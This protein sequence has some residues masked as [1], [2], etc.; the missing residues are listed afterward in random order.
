V[1]TTLDWA[2][3]YAGM[4]W[5]IIPIPPGEKYPKGFDRWH[6]LAVTSQRTIHDWWGNLFPDHGI[7]IATGQASGLWVLDVDD[8]TGGADTLADLE[9]TYGA[10]PD[11]WEVLTPGG[12][13]H[14]YFAWP[15]GATIRNDQAGRIGP[16]LDVRV[17]GGQVLAPPSIHPNGGRYEREASSPNHLAPAPDWLVDLLTAPERGAAGS[18][19]ASGGLLLSSSGDRPGDR[20]GLSWADL[21]RADGAT[22]IDCR[23]DRETNEWYELWSRPPMPGEEGFV[24]HTSASLN[25]KGSGVLK[26]FTPNWQGVTLDGERWS[27][28]QDKTYTRFGYW[29]VTRWGGDFKRAAKEADRLWPKEDGGC[30]PMAMV[31]SDDSSVATGPAADGRTTVADPAGAGPEPRLKPDLL[32]WA[33]DWSTFFQRDRTASDWLIEPLFARGRAHALYAAA[34]QGKSYVVLAVCAAAALGRPVL[35]R[36]AGDPLRILYVDYEMT[37][38]DLFDRLE[39]FGYDEE[40]APQ[41]AETL[42]YVQLPAIDPLDTAAGARTVVEAARYLAV[43]LVVIDTTARAISGEENDA[44]TYRDLARL[45]GVP[46]KAEGIAWVRI[47]HAG[48]EAEKGQRGSS[49]KNDDVDVVW[50]LKRGDEG[51]VLTAT[52]RRMSWVPERVEL[53]AHEGE[54]GVEFRLPGGG[55]VVHPDGTWHAVKA[56]DDLGLPLTVP[57]RKAG[58]ALRE[59]GHSFRNATIMAAIKARRERAGTLT[60]P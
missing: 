58:A 41:L 40:H 20:L 28:E 53:V 24:P 29:A 38:E 14:L 37:G 43:D 15:E 50:R 25:Y 35:G 46:L 42:H 11:T 39:E 60:V 1:T 44:D 36:R 22:F 34:K 9:H 31:G 6:E 48:K 21:L 19:R 23:L 57:R 17:E 56:L 8:R 54:E 55:E 10:L 45:L 33:V 30:G 26:L 13:R 47:D 27:L 59:A 7:G 12:G 4:G 5:R 51:V 49:A 2:L 16:G 3:A 18:T 32:N 52:H